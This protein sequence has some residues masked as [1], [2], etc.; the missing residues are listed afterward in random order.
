MMSLLAECV[1]KAKD[2][3]QSL[4]RMEVG[5]IS[6]TVSGEG[7]RQANCQSPLTVAV[8][9]RD[10]WAEPVRNRHK[11]RLV[12]D[13]QESQMKYCK[14]CSYVEQ[15]PFIVTECPDH[16]HTAAEVVALRLTTRVGNWAAEQLSALLLAARMVESEQ[17]WLGPKVVQMG[18]LVEQHA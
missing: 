8:I 6:V 16:F 11:A 7:S 13:R 18:G 12:I 10:T 15:Q 5:E 17:R 4:Q 1:N 14:P 9:W 3:G 2:S